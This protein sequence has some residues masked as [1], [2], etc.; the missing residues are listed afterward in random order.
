MRTFDTRVTALN[1]L[2]RLFDSRLESA[3]TDAEATV[4]TILADVRQ[5]GDAAV[6]DCTRRFSYAQAHTLR[7]S[8]ETVASAVAEIQQTPLWDAL[9]FAAT[10]IRSFHEKHKRTSW[11]DASQPGELLGQII[12]PLA[13]V[14]IYVPGG[15]ADYPSTVLM[16]CIPAQVAG[17]R[18]I[19]V[20]T[21]PNRETGTPPIAT[22]AALH[23]AGVTEIYAMGGSEAVGALAYG[24]ESIAR[25][26]KIFGPGNVY[27]NLAKKHVYGTV[28]IDL[29]AGPSEVAILA[30]EHADPVAAAAD[31]LT[32]CEHDINSSALVAS[33]SESFLKAVRAEIERQTATLPRA[34]IVLRALAANGFFILTRDIEEGAKIISLYAPEHLHLDVAEPY[35]LL[36]AIENAGAILIGRHTSAPI[37][38]YVAG[39]SHTLPT[40]GCARFASPLNVDDFTKKS[41]LLS[42]TGEVVSKLNATA[43]IMAEFEGLEA[44]ARRAR[45]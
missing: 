17:V 25:V 24:T 14:G 35:G 12:R 19:A 9:H 34:E 7:V 39:P 42:F 18:E 20:A 37:G 26:D 11:M 3:S 38:D 1:D 36:G 44:H 8:P 21:P 27:V 4:R 2:R 41:S 33:P 43:T 16:T 29:L 32:Q 6:L 30:D 22:L 23:I 45:D 13:R 31:I 10:R 5:R 15:T 40:A 28:G